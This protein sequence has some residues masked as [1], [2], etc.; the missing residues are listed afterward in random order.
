L[1]IFMKR[2]PVA[3]NGTRAA[4]PE[5]PGVAVNAM[6]TEG[7]GGSGSALNGTL[8][9]VSSTPAGGTIVVHARNGDASLD[10]PVPFAICN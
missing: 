1:L 7:S 8:E 6:K 9:V 5:T 2:W 4:L 10:G 3:T